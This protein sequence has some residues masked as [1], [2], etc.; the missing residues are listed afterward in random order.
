PSTLLFLHLYS[1][2]SDGF[3][4]CLDELLPALLSIDPCSKG[5]ARTDYLTAH[6]KAVRQAILLITEAARQAKKEVIIQTREPLDP[7]LVEFLLRIGINGICLEAEGLRENVE[8]IS[9]VEQNL[10]GDVEG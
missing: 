6:E 9:R 7:G 5:M 3:F 10:Q 4:V 2:V 8:L 1:Q